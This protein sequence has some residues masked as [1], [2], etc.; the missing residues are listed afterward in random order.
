MNCKLLMPTGLVVSLDVDPQEKILRN[1][2]FVEI[3]NNKAKET[4]KLVIDTDRAWKLLRML[5][6]TRDR[7]GP[8]NLNSVYRTKTYNK[9]VGGDAKS[10]H[11]KCWAFDWQKP[12]QTSA[13]RKDVT[14][15]WKSLCETF[16]EIGAI[17]YYTS[18]YHCEIGSDI[19]YGAT[20]FTIRDYRGKEGD[21]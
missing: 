10:C 8:M 2:R 20:T 17:N 5:Q 7:F 13:E 6:I 14:E 1:F 16:N 3:A 19:Q 11:L 15:W 21:W 9:T 18:G 4:C 12:N